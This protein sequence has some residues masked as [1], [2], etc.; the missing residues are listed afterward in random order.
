MQFAVKDGAEDVEKTVH[1]AQAFEQFL[2]AMAP[3]VHFSEAGLMSTGGE[4]FTPE[5]IRMAAKLGVSSDDLSKYSTAR[6]GAI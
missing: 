6:R 5:Q 1:F 2:E 4:Q 3:A